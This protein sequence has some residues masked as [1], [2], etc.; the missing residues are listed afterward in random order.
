LPQNNI[1]LALFLFNVGVELGQLALYFVMVLLWLAIDKIH[2]TGKPWQKYIPPYFIGTMA[3][4]WMIE[5][6]FANV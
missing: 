1:P 5:R 2:T 6:M 4:F 3:A